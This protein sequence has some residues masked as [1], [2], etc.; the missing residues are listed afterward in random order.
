M[1]GKGFWAGFLFVFVYLTSVLYPQWAGICRSTSSS[2]A[3]S[4][5]MECGGSEEAGAISAPYFRLYTMFIFT[6]HDRCTVRLCVIL[7]CRSNHQW[8]QYVPHFSLYRRELKWLNCVRFKIN[9]L[10]QFEHWD[11]LDFREI[12][13]IG[14]QVHVGLFNTTVSI[15]IT[16]D[17]FAC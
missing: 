7:G 4:T 1:R 3:S 9:P 13:C 8:I 11:L 17:G 12:V 15:E 6:F 2:F 5:G 14:R 10:H 16:L